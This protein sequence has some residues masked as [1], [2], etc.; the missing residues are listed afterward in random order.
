V[1]E[2]DPP[3]LEGTGQEEG[4]EVFTSTHTER[5]M[6]ATAYHEAGHATIAVW[7]G[8]QLASVEL[9]PDHPIHSGFCLE[10]VDDPYAMSLAVEL[11]DEEVILPQIK[12][13]LAGRA[14]QLKGGFDD[15]NGGD[16]HDIETALKVATRMVGCPCKAEELLDCLRT[17]TRK[18]LDVPVVWAGV[19]TLASNL[20]RMGTIIG[21]ECHRI[22][23]EVG[24]G[25]EMDCCVSDFVGS[26]SQRAWPHTTTV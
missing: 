7:F 6:R 1:G 10:K 23:T 25:R 26:S 17:D 12:I 21:E 9:T 22:L 3:R 4:K 14:A 18:L 19:E 11:G 2:H 15:V 8:L 5:E 13:L 24:I 20:L 16:S